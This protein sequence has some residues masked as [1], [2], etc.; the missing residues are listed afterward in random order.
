MALSKQMSIFSQFLQYKIRTKKF[1]D[2]KTIFG[3][4]KFFYENQICLNINFCN[5][6]GP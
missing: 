6:E 1:T 5:S 4:L 2:L 3:E